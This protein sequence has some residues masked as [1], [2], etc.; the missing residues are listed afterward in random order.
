MLLTHGRQFRP[1][2]VQ[3]T[4]VVP[5]RFDLNIAHLKKKFQSREHD[6]INFIKPERPLGSAL[7]ACDRLALLIAAL[8]HK[9]LLKCRFKGVDD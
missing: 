1:C 9:H 5:K 8:R 7:V 2:K 4:H 3:I 6:F